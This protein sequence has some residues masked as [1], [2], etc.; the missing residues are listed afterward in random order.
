MPTPLPYYLTPP[1]DPVVE[2]LGQYLL[3]VAR[4]CPANDA[5]W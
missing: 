3:T 2:M 5:H 4:G 1:Q